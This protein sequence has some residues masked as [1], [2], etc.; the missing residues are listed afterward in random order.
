MAWAR[1][2]LMPGLTR[3]ART[4]DEDVKRM[5]VVDRSSLDFFGDDIKVSCSLLF[6]LYIRRTFLMG[7][8]SCEK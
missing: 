7:R 6:L 4:S 1:G 8:G 2:E 3:I 5:G